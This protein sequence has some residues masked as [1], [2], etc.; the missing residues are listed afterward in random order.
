MRA[1]VCVCPSN[2]D[3]Q[4]YALTCVCV[5]CAHV[6]ETIKVKYYVQFHFSFLPLCDR[7]AF[8][9]NLSNLLVVA[10]AV[11]LRPSTTLVS[12]GVTMIMMGFNGSH[13]P[14]VVAIL[15]SPPACRLGMFGQFNVKKFSHVHTA[16]GFYESNFFALRCARL[17]ARLVCPFDQ[18][19]KH[20]LVCSFLW[21]VFFLFFNILLLLLFC[22]PC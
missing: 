18:L 2:A 9:A 16:E 21:H 8:A 4:L 10:P 1:P 5:Y 12:A 13:S 14:R 15:L 20:L 19:A 17:L 11:C 6:L 7:S 3:E 22:Y